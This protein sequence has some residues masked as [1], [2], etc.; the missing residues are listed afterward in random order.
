M[1]EAL[2]NYIEDLEDILVATERLNDGA[3]PVSI[4]EARR[5]LDLDR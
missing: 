4:E 1:R 2:E 5:I 3:P